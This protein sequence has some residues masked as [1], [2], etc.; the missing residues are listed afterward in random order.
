P[1]VTSRMAW[2][3]AECVGRAAVAAPDERRRLALGRR[4][5]RDRRRADRRPRRRA[6]EAA[7]RDESP[8]FVHG[9]RAARSRPV[10]DPR[11]VAPVFSAQY[12]W[13]R[14]RLAGGRAAAARGGL[15]GAALAGEW[16]PVV[17]VPRRLPV[18]GP[19]DPCAD[20]VDPALH[21][22]AAAQHL[23]R[24]GYPRRLRSDGLPGPGV[25]IGLRAL[26]TP[27]T[28]KALKVKRQ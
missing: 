26:T 2:R 12:R 13:G 19:G 4:G 5:V 28:H 8:S 25:R 21:C 18:A 7:R 22:T 15:R 27:N 1:A 14:I 16:T 20:H 23:D 6:R 10:L 11:R 9:L 17:A 24:C 3:M